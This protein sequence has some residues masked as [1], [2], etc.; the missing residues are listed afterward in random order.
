MHKKQLLSALVAGIVGTLGTTAQAD[1]PLSFNFNNAA[2]NGGVNQVV[3]VG[4]WDWSQ[5]SFLAENGSL[6]VEN[7][8]ATGGACPGD[9]CDFTVHTHATLTGVKDSLGV[10]TPIAGLGTGFEITTELA[11]TERVTGLTGAP[12]GLGTLASFSTLSGAGEYVNIYYQAAAPNTVDLSG[13]GFNDGL[14]ILA[15]SGILPSAGTFVITATT[16]TQFDQAFTGSPGPASDNYGDGSGT[17]GLSQLT[18]TGFGVQQEIR[19]D[20][21]KQDY[22]YFLNKLAPFG[23]NF[24]NISIGLPFNQVNPSDCFSQTAQTLGT[25]VAL[26]TGE[27]ANIHTDTLYSGQAADPNGGYLPVVGNINGLGPATGG[28]NGGPDFVAQT[29]INSAFTAIP[30]PGTLALLGIGFLSFGFSR[31]AGQRRA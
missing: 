15:G 25:S 9:V 7:Y 16:P 5:S 10:N 12:G 30:L 26:G 3:S 14:V 13:A 8:A 11:F 23:L 4:A 1:A 20:D 2:F 27:C 21:L 18:L 29:D 31:S 19:F 24:N 22:T 6:A 17:I 28:G